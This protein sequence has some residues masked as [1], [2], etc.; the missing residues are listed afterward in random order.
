MSATVRHPIFARAWQ[1]LS[2]CVEQEVGQY[3]SEL[4][5]GL[6]GHVLE[7]GAGNGANFAHYPATVERLD[8]LEPE[9]YL[10]AAAT[11]AAVDPTVAPAVSVG[12][13]TAEALPFA[14]G[15]FDA[16]VACLVLCTVGDP[17]RA[18]AE[19]H[20]VVRPGGE[21]RF[22]EHVRSDRAS[23]ARI[24]QRFDRYRLW[25]L[26]AGGCHCSR[27]TGPAIDAAGFTVE[28]RRS[29]ETRPTWSL[30]NPMIL[31]VARRPAG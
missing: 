17:G 19:L 30:T 9:A 10:R 23:K 2:G 31:G 8:A 28:Q 6:S 1:L 27:E 11:R 14:D 3:R 26:V 7:I 4:L 25:P 24:Q 22:L 15:T 13:A 29:V 21:L 20:R 18:L 5:A 12:D 16:A